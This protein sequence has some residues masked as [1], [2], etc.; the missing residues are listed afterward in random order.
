MPLCVLGRETLPHVEHGIPPCV[1]VQL[2][3]VLLGSLLTIAVNGVALNC[4]LASTGMSALVGETETVI[5]GMVMV[6]E[7]DANGS[8]TEVAVIVTVRSLVSVGGL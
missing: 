5:A 8:A 1:R 3:K 7:V 6:A 4:E 2:A